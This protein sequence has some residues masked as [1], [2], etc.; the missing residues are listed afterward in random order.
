VGGNNNR[1]LKKLLHEEPLI[2]L[3]A[4]YYIR[5]QIEDNQMGGTFGSCGKEEEINRRLCCG[6]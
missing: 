3:L 6:H 4:R 5:S 1:G 2:I